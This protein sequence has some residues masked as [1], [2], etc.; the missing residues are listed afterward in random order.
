MKT[1][2]KEKRDLFLSSIEELD[3]VET[4]AKKRI[5]LLKRIKAIHKW[6]KHNEN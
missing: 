5:I 2:W 6:F 4:K 1:E 3:K